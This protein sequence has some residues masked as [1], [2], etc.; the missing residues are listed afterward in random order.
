MTNDVSCARVQSANSPL[1]Y[2]SRAKPLPLLP[3]EYVTLT[4]FLLSPSV[5]GRIFFYSPR[6]RTRFS[7]CTWR[8]I[9]KRCVKN[10]RQNINLCKASARVCVFYM[11]KHFF[12]SNA[13]KKRSSIV[14]KKRNYL[15]MWKGFF[16]ECFVISSSKVS[17]IL[18]HL[19]FIVYI[20]NYGSEKFELP[21]KC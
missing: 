5:G 3:P 19:Y 1:R 13:E 18:I 21:K 9:F 20:L 7:F 11:H 4:E 16:I 10:N 6:A 15:T 8:N 17:Y 2:R 14:W 12:L